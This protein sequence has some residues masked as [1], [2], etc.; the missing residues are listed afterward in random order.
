MSDTP[1]RSA[2]RPSA[3]STRPAAA[4]RAR[5][6]AGR[7]VSSKRV[8]ASS[9]KSAK[10]A[11]TAK[12]TATKKPPATRK[13][14]AAK[15]SAA[16][17]KPVATAAKPMATKEPSMTSGGPAS[18]EPVELYLLRHADAGDPMTWAGDDAE[19]PLSEKGRRQA[20]RLGSLLAGIKLRPDVILTSPKLRAADTA[21]IVGKA[22]SVKPQKDDR[23][24]T[25]VELGDLA[26]LLAGNEEAR[27]VVLV[28]HDPDFSTLASSLTGAAIELKKGAIAR[29][30]LGD[31]G[32]RAGGGALRWLLPPGVLTD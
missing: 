4:P 12:P 23:L 7:F 21:K 17:K 16:A 18:T 27:R 5:G 6:A 25:S 32:P 1:R 20:K 15:E 2:R 28:G 8:V 9:T 11:T 10:A 14:A 24:G 31:R 19:R 3:T 30:D 13:P 29:I 26:S 22:V